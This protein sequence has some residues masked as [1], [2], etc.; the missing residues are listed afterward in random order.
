MNSSRFALRNLILRLVAPRAS[1]S[2][3]SAMVGSRVHYIP[4][5]LF[6]PRIIP[7]HPITVR[8]IV[9]LIVVAAAGA[10][11]AATPPPLRV[12]HAAVASDHPLASAAGVAALKAGGNAVD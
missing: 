10:A 12:P 4:I 2:L 3:G 7:D 1:L 8:L 11:G 5:G 9:V 6:K